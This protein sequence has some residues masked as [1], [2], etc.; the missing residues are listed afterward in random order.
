MLYLI[1]CDRYDETR[2]HQRFAEVLAKEWRIKDAQ[3]T[4]AMSWFMERVRWVETPDGLVPL[5]Q[6]EE[7]NKEEFLRR[8]VESN[9][10]LPREQRRGPGTTNAHNLRRYLDRAI[11]DHGA[12]IEK[13]RDA[14][15]RGSTRREAEAETLLSECSGQSF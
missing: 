6:E 10:L 5:L 8:K 9:R 7:P 4:L 11:S 2:V 13:W 12:L 14:L 15:L 1:L 3:V